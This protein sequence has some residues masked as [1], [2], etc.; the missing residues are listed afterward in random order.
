MGTDRIFELVIRLAAMIK[1]ADNGEIRL[2]MND[3]TELILSF[4]RRKNL[5]VC[6]DE[7]GIMPDDS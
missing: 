6:H 5:Y 4:R 2:R 1:T 7:D 3:G